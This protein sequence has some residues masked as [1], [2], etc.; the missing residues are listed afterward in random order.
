MTELEELLAKAERY[1]ATEE[2][3]YT[4]VSDDFNYM[5]PDDDNMLLALVL[6]ETAGLLS[7]AEI[8]SAIQIVADCPS[9]ETY[10]TVLLPLYRELLAKKTQQ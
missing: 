6:S 10:A 9:W 8:Y 2:E 5:S 1:A 7:T 3:D 4:L